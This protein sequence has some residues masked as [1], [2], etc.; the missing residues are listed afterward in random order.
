ML[1]LKEKMTRK[2]T[3]ASATIKDLSAKF[4]KINVE[5]I[6]GREKR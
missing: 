5:F 2:E 1:E 3:E 4:E 6:E